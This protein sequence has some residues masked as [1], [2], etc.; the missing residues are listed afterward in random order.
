MF[1][2]LLDGVIFSL[3]LD[4]HL[5]DGVVPYTELSQG[6]IDVF[7]TD[8][9]SST[10]LKQISSRWLHLLKSAI[11]VN[12]GSITTLAGKTLVILSLYDYLAARALSFNHKILRELILRRNTD[13]LSMSDNLFFWRSSTLRLRRSLIGITML[14]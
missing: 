10:W 3:R 4:R 6:I 5:R 7:E 9:D 8:L 13:T 11:V 2:L 1:S 12:V 14:I